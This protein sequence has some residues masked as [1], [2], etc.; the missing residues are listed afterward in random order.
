MI[1]ENRQ[2]IYELSNHLG[3]VMVTVSDKRLGQDDGTGKAGYYLA[4]VTSATDYYPFG[5]V[6]PGRTFSSQN[7]RFGFN[8]HEKE[9]TDWTGNDG[10]VLDFGARIYDAKLGRF[11][12]TDPWEDKYAWQTPYAYFKNSPIATID[13]MGFGDEDDVQSE[14]N[15]STCEKNGDSETSNKQYSYNLSTS[16]NT[17]QTTFVSISVTTT[18]IEGGYKKEF[19]T[20]VTTMTTTYDE[21]D[22]VFSREVTDAST[23]S[24]ESLI[25]TDEE[26]APNIAYD[27]LP[28][29][30]SNVSPFQIQ[31]AEGAMHPTFKVMDKHRKETSNSFYLMTPNYI[32]LVNSLNVA[33]GLYM[34]WG[35]TGLSGIS[36]SSQTA[37]NI[38]SV[39]AATHFSYV[40]YLDAKMKA[41]T[42]RQNG[43][44]YTST[45]SSSKGKSLSQFLFNRKSK[46]N[47]SIRDY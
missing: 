43:S 16:N 33:G 39:L 47:R 45:Y 20:N 46:S 35:A 3:N 24:K 12:S 2:N 26:V 31:Y 19:N 8:G 30:E 15:C 10:S 25:F 37:L 40:G 28:Y 14:A 44:V 36:V 4:D 21:D 41:K 32:S 17:E 22:N 1:K 11:L 18:K 9:G 7:Y 5:M 13:F 34:S 42:K 23:Y 27:N 29:K 6:Q 38:S